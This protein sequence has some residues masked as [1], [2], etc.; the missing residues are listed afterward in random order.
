[1][2]NQCKG[3]MGPKGVNSSGTGSLE[4]TVWKKPKKQVQATWHHNFC[5][6]ILKGPKKYNQTLYFAL[7][8]LWSVAY[9]HCSDS[10]SVSC[11]SCINNPLDSANCHG[12]K[13]FPART[14]GNF[15]ILVSQTILPPSLELGLVSAASVG[16]KLI[17]K[18]PFLA[19]SGLIFRMCNL[20]I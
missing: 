3:K 8:Q 15:Q 1:M 19:L 14:G 4:H 13:P 6:L 7:S 10:E 2:S 16:E 18:F 9:R 12:N 5:F 17:K 20:V 11:V